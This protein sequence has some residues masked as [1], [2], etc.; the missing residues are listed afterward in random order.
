MEF[1]PQES[2]VFLIRQTFFS[3]KK[4]VD[5]R[6]RAHGFEFS[7]EQGGILM[8]LWKKDGQSQGELA[9]FLGKDKTTIV[10]LIDSMEK[11]LLVVRIPS[12][13]DRRINLIYLTNKGKEVQKEVMESLKETLHDSL[14]SVSDQEEEIA[15]KVLK[16]MYSNLSPINNNSKTDNLD[17]SC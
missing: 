2:L 5:C 16:K 12:K 7:M 13:N 8:H 9:E 3:F 10:R 11:S 6:L 17:F 1:E 14:E 4:S 15:K